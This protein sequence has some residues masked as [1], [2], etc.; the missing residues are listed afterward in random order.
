MAFQ[1]GTAM[2]HTDFFTKLVDFLENDP[3]LVGLGQQWTTVWQANPTDPN[4]TARVLSGPGL[5][6][7]DEVFV[8]I[9]LFED[10]LSGFY[11]IRS[12]G[13]TDIIASA[14]QLSE[15]VN[16]SPEVRVF[17]NIS[18]FDYWFVANGRRFII[19]AQI[20]TVV[21]T[22][23]FGL[24][25]P[26]AQPPNYP[27]PLFIGGMAGP[28]TDSQIDD[29]RSTADAH[30]DYL[31]PFVDTSAS[32]PAA[33]NAY[34]LEPAGAW[35]DHASRGAGS[36]SAETLARVMVHPYE[37]GREL[38]SSRELTDSRLLLENTI[39]TYGGDFLT[40]PVT[41]FAE[42]ATQQVYGI[43]DGVFAVQGINNAN[44]NTVTIDGTDHIVFQN[45]FRT[46][47]D[48][49]HAVRLD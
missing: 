35:R 31:H 2:G 49:F 8:G 19:A 30:T 42:Q 25:Q 44:Q 37:G 1:I 7:G 21:E 48:Q 5:A 26:Y 10:V 22:G 32:S 29:F 6:G 13:M 39:E 15:H 33:S 40:Q 11:E 20:S 38:F 45:A 9:E 17:L 47:T 24:I 34:L 46:E 3:T 18:P 43:L 12:R 36:T 16:V 23:Y 4:P 14:T 27:F 28:R 41:L